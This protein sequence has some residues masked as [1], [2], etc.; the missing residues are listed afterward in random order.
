[1]LMIYYIMVKRGLKKVEEVPPKYIDEVRALLD[2]EKIVE[3][4]NEEMDD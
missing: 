4:D 1:M 3:K 2:A